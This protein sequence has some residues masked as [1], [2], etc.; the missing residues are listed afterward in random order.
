[1]KTPSK[2]VYHKKFTV[3]RANNT[4]TQT[5]LPTSRARQEEEQ[6]EPRHLPP[7]RKTS[8]QS[9]KKRLGKIG[10]AKAAPKPQE[11]RTPPER[12]SPS[13]DLPVSI[14][15]SPSKTLA[16][17]APKRAGRLGTIGGKKKEKTPTPTPEPE[18]QPTREVSLSPIP[19]PKPKSRLGVI[20]GKPHP[21][22]KE[23]EQDAETKLSRRTA[24]PEP[25]T[26]EVLAP[27][28][29]PQSESVEP[30]PEATEEEK[31][32]RKRDEL[33]RQLDAKA[34][35]PAKKKRKF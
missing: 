5:P 11:S 31:A 33:K 1:V 26:T 6:N 27:K 17:P 7:L 14:E 4:Q 30:T 35:A 21:K 15:R 22:R 12:K 23:K 2:S 24:I 28:T 19:S 20:G 34:K 16:S 3:V 32:N 9:S 8:P 10:G 25:S 29:K 18:F 13:G